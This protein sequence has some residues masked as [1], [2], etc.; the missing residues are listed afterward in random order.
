MPRIV[1]PAKFEQQLALFKSI[2]QKHDADG[3]ASPLLAFLAQN[4][5]DLNQHDADADTAALRHDSFKHQSRFTE[6]FRQQRDN[7]LKLPWKH[8][9]LAAQFLKALYPKN[10]RTLG[11]WSITVNNKNKLVYPR[12]ISER[13]TLVKDFIA[14]HNSFAPGSSPL[15]IFLSE[16]EIDF[17][18]DLAAVNSAETLHDQFSSASRSKESERQQR[19]VL[20]QPI[21]K[22]V[23]STG[24][25]IKALFRGHEHKAGQYG[26]TVDSSKRKPHLRHSMLL[27]GKSITIKGVAMGSVFTNLGKDALHLQKPG[28]RSSEPIVISPKQRFEIP[29]GYTNLVIFNPSRMENGSFSAYIHI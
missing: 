18:T 21:M 19:D 2:K 13:I 20:W 7:A 1:Y 11:D 23:R 15:E 26:F 29:K 22:N 10:A 3:P 8:L 24:S 16:N 9:K 27:C 25:F 4:N 6:N 14:K 12:K 28:K 5:I 17:T